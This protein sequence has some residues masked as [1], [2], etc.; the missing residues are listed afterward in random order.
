MKNQGAYATPLAWPFTNSA[1]S[2]P[3]GDARGLSKRTAP[4]KGGTPTVVA[5]GIESR[6]E[7][8]HLG[9]TW[10]QLHVPD[11][12]ERMIGFSVPQGDTVLVGSYEGMHLITL[13]DPA[14]VE[15]DYEYT[16]FDCYNPGTGIAHHLGRDWQIVGPY[17]GRPHHFSTLGEELQ[18]D[19]K[20]LTNSVVRYGQVTWTSSYKNFSGDW[21]AAT[22]SPDGRF[23]VLTCPYDVDSRIW[24]RTVD[25]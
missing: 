25:I 6:Q 10:K 2:K 18:L 17:P 24:E 3:E 23:I 16:E 9:S 5:L 13:S 22:F 15:T 7:I 19:A 21:A 8:F 11:Y 14:I 1:T 4:P 12:C 20:T